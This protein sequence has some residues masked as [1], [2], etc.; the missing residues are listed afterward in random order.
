MSFPQQPA[1]PN[2]E[3]AT[4]SDPKL[5]QSKKRST[6]ENREVAIPPPI[7]TTPK[8]PLS[9][10][11]PLLPLGPHI[12]THTSNPPNHPRIQNSGGIQ[13]NLMDAPVDPSDKTCRDGEQIISEIMHNPL[14]PQQVHHGSQNI[15]HLEQPLTG[16]SIANAN[17]TPTDQQQVE[18][19]HWRFQKTQPI[20][21]SP[22]IHSLQQAETPLSAL[23]SQPMILANILGSQSNASRD[24]AN[25]EQVKPRDPS[26]PQNAVSPNSILM[27]IHLSEV[28]NQAVQHS[29]HFHFLPTRLILWIGSQPS[30]PDE[31]WVVLHH[32]SVAPCHASIHYQNSYVWIQNEGSGNTWINEQK[33]EPKQNTI[34]TAL[35]QIKLGD[36]VLECRLET[37]EEVAAKQSRGLDQPYS[38]TPPKTTDASPTSPKK[39]SLQ[40]TSK[41]KHDLGFVIAEFSIT[42]LDQPYAVPHRGEILNS[43]L[44]FLIGRSPRCDYQVEFGERYVAEEQAMIQYFPQKQL[45]TIKN[46]VPTNAIFVNSKQIEME[47]LNFGDEIKLGVA[48]H[49]PR[50]RFDASSETTTKASKP[51]IEPRELLMSNVLPR[52]QRGQIY[53]IGSHPRSLIRLTGDAIPE[54]VAEILVPSEGDYF[55]VRKVGEHTIPVI[56]DQKVL[57][58]AVR[59]QERYGVN[60]LLYIGEHLCIRNNQRTLPPEIRS[61]PWGKFFSMV[62]WCLFVS[63]LLAG[64]YLLAQ[65]NWPKIQ[66]NIREQNQLKQYQKN[67]WFVAGVNPEAQEV[68]SGTGFLITQKDAFDQDVLYVVTCKHVIQPWK[69]QPHKIQDN[70]VYNR[71]GK[72]IAYLNSNDPGKKQSIAAWPQSSQVI[73]MENGHP[74]ILENSFCDLPL[75]SKLGEIEIYRIGQDEYIEHPDGFQEHHPQ[76]NFDVAILKITPAPDWKYP[77]HSWQISDEQTLEVNEEVTVLAY[78]SGRARLLNKQG[79]AIPANT[80]GTLTSECTTPHFVELDVNQDQGASGGP[81]VNQAG[82]IVAMLTFS[83][84]N[85]RLIYGIHGQIIV[86][87]MK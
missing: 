52:P 43:R 13:D 15:N 82:Q 48:A 45:F 81:V 46:L 57:E 85:K 87:L 53:G 4:S 24:G 56:L 8:I 21:I 40:D 84:K 60:Q 35:C 5:L 44:N 26:N 77:Y 22:T 18:K 31:P 63:G 65:A 3:G 32:T 37:P 11:T 39:N 7:N 83:D 12:S 6:I 62:F 61:F 80:K 42:S 66:H 79:L 58:P 50:I 23:S 9:T 17:T 41:F 29:Y 47:R 55:L 86:E 68:S 36:L 30:L 38:M 75:Q 74:F 10:N 70:K 34:L 2:N 72:I 25:D 49:A 54:Q 33:L 71:E 73:K 19:A 64:I 78:P 27:Q 51:K 67:V 14:L 28:S 16:T 20:A 69:F 1:N 59:P 76:T